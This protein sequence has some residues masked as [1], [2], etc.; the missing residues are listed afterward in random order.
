M[1]TITQLGLTSEKWKLDVVEFLKRRG[2]CR[3]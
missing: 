2:Y 3:I 1:D